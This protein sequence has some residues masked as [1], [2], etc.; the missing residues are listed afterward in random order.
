METLAG[1]DKIVGSLTFAQVIAIETF[2][3]LFPSVT[4]EMLSADGLEIW[5]LCSKF[6]G[7]FLLCQVS[8]QAGAFL[9]ACWGPALKT[10]AL[11]RRIKAYVKKKHEEQEKE[12]TAPFLVQS[13]V[14]YTSS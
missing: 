9:I 3:C 11:W 12:L 5:R 10:L 4:I 8:L 6:N 14:S 2:C 13:R 7:G 1:F